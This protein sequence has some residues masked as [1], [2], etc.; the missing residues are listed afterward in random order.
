MVL[1]MFL[2]MVHLFRF[3]HRWNLQ[4]GIH[5]LRYLKVML[6]APLDTWVGMTT[7]WKEVSNKLV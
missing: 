1:S 7:S 3:K 5:V 2:V 4:S 6:S